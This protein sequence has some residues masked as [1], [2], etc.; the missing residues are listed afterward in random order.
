[1]TRGTAQDHRTAEAHTREIFA[2]LESTST[3]R[4]S[5]LRRHIL[6]PTYKDGILHLICSGGL[7]DPETGHPTGILPI[8]SLL[9][10][11]YD[12]PEINWRALL[13][14]PVDE[15]P[16]RLAYLAHVM[17][18]AFERRHLEIARSTG[19]QPQVIHLTDPR[20]I[21]F[22]SGFLQKTLYAQ[23]LP[24]WGVPAVYVSPLGQ[25][26]HK[27]PILSDCSR[28]VFIDRRINDQ[29]YSRGYVFTLDPSSIFY[30]DRKANICYRSTF[31]QQVYDRCPTLLP[32]DE[33]ITDHAAT[34]ERLCEECRK[35][36]HPFERLER[37]IE[38]ASHLE[39]SVLGFALFE[40]THE[41]ASDHSPNL[42]KA[43][44]L[45]RDLDNQQRRLWSM[46]S[47]KLPSISCL[48]RILNE[49][50]LPD[51]VFIS[52]A[53]THVLCKLRAFLGDDYK[54][55]GN[56]AR[57]FLLFKLD[58]QM[59]WEDRDRSSQ[60]Q[61]LPR[62]ATLTVPRTLRSWCNV[63][64]DRVLFQSA[65]CPTGEPR[66][67]GVPPEWREV[68]RRHRF[69]VEFE[70]FAENLCTHTHH[71]LL[72]QEIG[73]LAIP[74]QPDPRGEMLL[75]PSVKEG[76]VERANLASVAFRDGQ[77]T[78]R[79]SREAVQVN[80]CRRDLAGFDSKA[81]R[82]FGFLYRR[83]PVSPQD[84]YRQIFQRV[85]A[86]ATSA[87]I[88]LASRL[89]RT[90]HVIVIIPF[91]KEND[92]YIGVSIE[93]ADALVA[94]GR[95]VILA[96]AT[97]KDPAD[98]VVSIAKVEAAI[99]S[100]PRL[101]GRV[102][103]LS[104][105]TSEVNDLGH[106]MI[107]KYLN[108]HVGLSAARTAMDADVEVPFVAVLEGDLQ[109]VAS[110]WEEVFRSDPISV[111]VTLF[112]ADV[113]I[114][115]TD[116]G[117]HCSEVTFD[118]SDTLLAQCVAGPLSAAIFGKR[119]GSIFGGSFLLRAD[120]IDPML[121][122]LNRSEHLESL[123][124]TW[125]L[126]VIRQMGSCRRLT[127]PTKVHLTTDEVRDDGADGLA[128]KWVADLFKSVASYIMHDTQRGLGCEFVG[129]DFPGGEIAPS[130]KRYIDRRLD[131]LEEFA[132]LEGR[133]GGIVGDRLLNAH[134]CALHAVQRA[135]EG[136]VGERQD[137]VVSADDWAETV[138]SFLVR[139][140]D[141]GLN[142]S[143]DLFAFRWLLDLRTLGFYFGWKRVVTD[144]LPSRK[145][146]R[147]CRQAIAAERRRRVARSIT[148]P[149]AR[150]T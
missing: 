31:A 97:N 45:L 25:D 14:G 84:A 21:P 47:F 76:L 29:H 9:H 126:P 46:G 129:G 32:G 108:V 104:I 79:P 34:L 27:N 102:H 105:C 65:E 133:V 64:H 128:I 53:S 93:S 139:I 62:G 48:R 69:T 20:N 149:T 107:E 127:V 49:H 96:L 56:C 95:D 37:I 61:A 24:Y 35:I 112:Q 66:L 109:R 124:E 17:L 82:T 57:L 60:S 113:R 2:S 68:L 115:Q 30:L 36:P 63:S 100:R 89:R 121:S 150:G 58:W 74:F 122:H 146:V 136:D 18:I 44:R 13:D 43:N 144:P 142:A 114:A 75:M 52:R 110:W 4:W 132:E 123:V 11:H 22:Y 67:T 73:C 6:S 138:I 50:E 103:V 117:L 85:V 111:G 86:D 120:G 55:A 51:E 19:P 118:N 72:S 147:R 77:F 101:R 137:L 94:Q 145:I 70:R 99:R 10:V 143:D 26:G 41:F 140:W 80:V 5:D 78:V 16:P 23:A 92:S 88:S 98:A 87:T 90:Q 134:R 39:Y 135:W 15:V 3:A 1:M 131:R 8:R 40:F 141:E 116:D 83:D 42:H 33:E 28:D 148:V 91:Y 71:I 125:L 106:W 59:R 130:D 81:K 119:V 7:A 38:V 54:E 12:Y